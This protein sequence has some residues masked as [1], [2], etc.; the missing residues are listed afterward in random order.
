MKENK[1]VTPDQDGEQRNDDKATSQ[2]LQDELMKPA[3][4]GKKDPAKSSPQE[5]LVPYQN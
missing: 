5:K 1:N 4:I 2:S 3:D